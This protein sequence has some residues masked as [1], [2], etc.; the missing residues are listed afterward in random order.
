MYERGVRTKENH[1]SNWFKFASLLY[2]RM[3]SLNLSEYFKII[4]NFLVKRKMADVWML[5]Y[6]NEIRAHLEI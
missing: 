1:I 5:S 2:D 6:Q 3:S 4:S